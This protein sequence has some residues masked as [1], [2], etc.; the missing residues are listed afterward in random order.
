MQSTI[1]DKKK[2]IS[3]GT[4][5]NGMEFASI[6]NGSKAVLILLGGPGNEISQ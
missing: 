4:F 1:T 6:G 5:T 2:N 3:R